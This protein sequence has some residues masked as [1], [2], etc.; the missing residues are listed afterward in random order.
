MAKFPTNQ[1]R[2]FLRNITQS[3]AMGGLAV[4]V[5]FGSV[6]AK[7]SRSTIYYVDANANG[8][9]NGSSWVNAYSHLQDALAVALS[10]DEI[11]VA[12]GIY[13]PDRG[14][15]IELGDRQATFQ[16][17]NGVIIK[18]GYAGCSE[19]D[20]DAKDIKLYETVLSG[21]LNRDD[22]TVIF[23]FS[24]EN[25]SSRFD[26]SYHIITASLVDETAVL[27]GF[28]IRKAHNNILPGSHFGW[29]GGGMSISEGSPTIMNCTFSENYAVNGAGVFNI[30][31]NASFINC[32]FE[33]NLAGESGGGMYVRQSNPTIT[34]CNF[35]RNWAVNGAG[36]Y[37]QESHPIITYCDFNGYWGFG[38]GIYNYWYSNPTISNCTIINNKSE[39]GGGIACNENSSPIIKNCLIQGNSAYQLGGGIDC[40][41]YSNPDISNCM[42]INNDS[43][44]GNGG[45]ISCYNYSNPKISNCNLVGNEASGGEGAG[46]YCG[47]RSDPAIKY[48]L[49]A[50]NNYSAVACSDSSPLFENCTMIKS[51]YG[52]FCYM[53]STPTVNNC[54]VRENNENLQ[55][56]EES[57]FRINYCNIQGGWQGIGN[58]DVDPL[59]VDAENGDYHLK[60]QAGSWDPKIYQWVKDS[61]TSPCCSPSARSGT[62]GC[63]EVK[64]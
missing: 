7:N 61:V 63:R 24:L 19:T 21:D 16:L 13:E 32:T 38:G 64:G 35:N 23:P 17:I 28:T 40:E 2:H 56:V 44:E 1:F 34:K 25:G 22:A 42:I 58:I 14:A 3:L 48:C 20:P 49:F 57:E 54:I 53:Q 55:L 60:S 18:G 62:V 5:I 11:R 45:G 52:I 4:S 41:S 27:D 46:I 47:N 39:F 36:I 33:R 10:G 15:G 29:Y 51:Y 6:T 30:K 12:K 9:N 43:E 59:F 26:N 8:S 37:N 50:A 31:G